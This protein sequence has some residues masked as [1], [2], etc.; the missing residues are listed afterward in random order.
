MKV[1]QQPVVL[2]TYLGRD[3]ATKTDLAVP[4]VAAGQQVESEQFKVGPRG[5]GVDLDGDGKVDAKNDGF[6]AFPTSDGKY[7][8]T[9]A[10][11]ILKAFAGDHDF[12]NDGKVSDDEKAR[13][14]KLAGQG[15]GLDL[16]KDGVLS[17]WEL[18]KAGAAV[19][20]TKNGKD[21]AVELQLA[22]LQGPNEREQ[23]EIAMFQQ[24][25]SYMQMMYHFNQNSMLMNQ[26]FMMTPLVNGSFGFGPAA[27][28]GFGGYPT[29]LAMPIY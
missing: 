25:Q 19:V 21:G 15:E 1:K 17:G 22:D 28:G 23:L 9:K 16:D 13:G 14:A 29:G 24:Q 27:M 18:Q 8:T 4:S 11:N 10:N 5:F 26:S 12:D 6:L 20:K 2:K 3:V 7:D